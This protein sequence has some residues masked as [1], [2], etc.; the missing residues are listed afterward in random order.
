MTDSSTR[1][2]RV[3]APFID[4]HHPTK[5]ENNLAVVIGINDYN[6]GIPPLRTARADAKRLDEILT[7]HHNYEVNLLVEEVSSQRLTTLLHEELPKQ[8]GKDDRLLFYFAGHGIALD[9]DDG[10]AGHLI[11]QDADGADSSTFLPMKTVHDA[12]TALPCRHCLIILDC[13]FSGAFRWAAMRNLSM[14]PSTLYRERYERYLR[15]PAWQIVT[16]AAYDQEALDSLTGAGFG[17]RNDEGQ[18]H[19]PFAQ[20]LFRALEGEGDANQDGVLIATEL[21]LF[22]RD[23]VEVKAEVEAR[24]RQTPGLW[25]LDKHDKGEFVFLLGEPKLDPAPKLTTENNPY[26]GLQSY[27]TEHAELFFGRRALLKQLA[28]LVET[29]PLTVVLGASGT[30]KSS[31]VKAGVVTYLETIR[32]DE[33]DRQAGH[34]FVPRILRPSDAPLNALAQAVATLGMESRKDQ[35]SAS[36]EAIHAHVE[37]WLSAHQ[38]E[39]LLL[40]IDQFEELVTLCRDAAKREQFQKVL[41]DLLNRYP[42]RV[43]LILT[44]RTDF[45]SHFV[46]SPLSTRW[47][48]S[49]FV[50]P[51]MTQADLRE[52]IEGPAGVRV[53]FFEPAELVEELIDEV[54][55]TP[56]ALPLLSFTLEQLYLKYLERQEA[57]QE[58]GVIIERSLT[59][60]DYKSLGG[61]IG[62]LR[63]RAEKEYRALPDKLHKETMQRVMLRMVAIEG[64]ELARRRV[65]LHELVY[66]SNAENKRVTTIIDRLVEARLLVR[67][68]AEGD[69]NGGSDA[70]VEP[71]HDA[72]VRAWDRL[73]RWKQGFEEYLTLQ[74]TLTAAANSWAQDGQ[75]AKS[76]LLWNYNPRL[77]QL[78]VIVSP[79]TNG[80]TNSNNVLR[81]ARQSLWPP[82][83]VTDEP[84]WLNRLETEFVQMS[85]VRRANVLKRIVGIT[86]LV[87][88]AL[89]GLTGLAEVRRREA[90]AQEQTAIAERNRADQNA[91]AESTAAANENIARQTAEAESDARATEVAVRATAEAEAIEQ[92]QRTQSAQLSILA[93][94]ELD[95]PTDPSGSLGLILARRAAEATYKDYDYVLPNASRDLQDAIKSAS[96][97][98]ANLPTQSH[99]GGINEAEFSPDGSLIATAGSDSYVMLWS[100]E[101]GEHQ[102]TM[103]GHRA[104]V[105]LID[106]SVN[107]TQIATVSEDGTFII[108]D[109]NSGEKIQIVSIPDREVGSIDFSPDGRRIVTAGSDKMLRVW[110]AESGRELFTI[111]APDVNT[112]ADPI[113]FGV[114]IGDELLRTKTKS[115][116]YSAQYSEDGRSI[117]SAGSNGL[118]VMW[119]SS[120]GK[121]E[122]FL[123]GRDASQEEI[124]IIK[125]GKEDALE[126][127]HAIVWHEDS[128]I[129]RLTTSDTSFRLASFVPTE[130]FV[131]SSSD[132]SVQLW[133]I[134]AGVIRTLMEDAADAAL[135]PNQ[136]HIALSNGETSRVIEVDTGT[137]VWDTKVDEKPFGSDFLGWFILGGQLGLH[138]C[139]EKRCLY[140]LL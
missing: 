31:L 73:L 17:T 120:T 46:D 86:V 60:E 119:N 92:T 101:T 122:K 45:E 32:Q 4:L 64:G 99:L 128:E 74:R 65:P 52:V 49:R 35:T 43:H 51:P 14:P 129:P 135:S 138:F 96:P 44:L 90:V 36:V 12:L 63:T 104:K 22:L 85:V 115:D 70:Y 81:T 117:I 111:S 53:L 77:P 76:G 13:C 107:G 9:G 95:S 123:S 94:N 133:K 134:D 16:S 105:N 80:N 116:F 71:A 75:D 68:R 30:G 106:F 136:N 140:F 79:D 15:S 62:S 72:L 69:G 1:K 84:T 57:A 27:D 18:N 25:P 39:R 47:Q 41:R 3:K 48:D 103:I 93:R 139:K 7:K 102:K 114:R 127:V 50:V 38:D 87:V 37:S 10:P 61:V 131:L 137:I 98:I 97:W 21:Y 66:P 130:D 5:F 83:T 23:N 88:I 112:F 26:R 78:Q 58:S 100:A 110:D 56:G 125:N 24:H 55:Q 2:V 109:A 108:W 29:Q 11:P 8:M 20:A 118:I 54:I 6:H 40:V 34:V 89:I 28:E 42:N 121:L 33:R 126:N 113:V 82:T 67:D 91:A 19:S 132:D 59:M 124:D